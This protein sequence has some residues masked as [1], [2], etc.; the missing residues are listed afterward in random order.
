MERVE[1]VG[2]ARLRT[3]L[4]GL[5]EEQIG[6]L[7]VA[8]RAA[9]EASRRVVADGVAPEQERAL[10]PAESGYSDRAL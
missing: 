8:L 1:P 7:C 2:A 10:A 3:G 4:P 5:R 9:L 6:E